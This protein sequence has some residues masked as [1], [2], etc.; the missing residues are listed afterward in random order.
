MDTKKS[1][2][3]TLVFQKRDTCEKQYPSLNV[4]IAGGT[5]PQGYP[6]S[7]PGLRRSNFPLKRKKE[8]EGESLALLRI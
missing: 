2:D 1:V 8:R 3:G 7:H 5:S 4:R 6:G